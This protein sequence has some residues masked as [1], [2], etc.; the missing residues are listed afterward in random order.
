[1]NAYE[2]LVANIRDYLARPGILNDGF[3][4]DSYARQVV[5]EQEIIDGELHFEIPGL[6]T[7]SGNPNAVIFDA[8]AYAAELDADEAAQ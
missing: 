4:P 2:T 3:D 6:H 5:A 7:A 8:S 1:M